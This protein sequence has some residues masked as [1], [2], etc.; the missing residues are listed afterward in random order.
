MAEPHGN[1][2]LLPREILD[3]VVD[4]FGP[5]TL[6]HAYSLPAETRETLLACVRVSHAWRAA[7]LPHLYKRVHL[8]TAKQH[9]SFHNAIVNNLGLAS[10][11][12]HLAV[13]DFKYSLC[14]P[15]LSTFTDIVRRICVERKLRSFYV[16]KC[17]MGFPDDKDLSEQN[18]EFL[19]GTDPSACY[20]MVTELRRS[21]E[22]LVDNTREEYALKQIVSTFLDFF[23]NRSR[24]EGLNGGWMDHHGLHRLAMRS[25]HITEEMIKNVGWRRNMPHLRTLIIDDPVV[26]ALYK[27]GKL[28]DM[29]ESLTHIAMSMHPEA[30]LIL[31][32]N[33]WNIKPWVDEFTQMKASKLKLLKECCRMTVLNK[34]SESVGWMDDKALDGT[35]WTIVQDKHNENVHQLYP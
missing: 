30:H 6:E 18:R 3:Q 16:H 34:A 29:L 10:H 14:E 5:P 12:E 26:P 15:A 4:Y 31:A 33:Y 35:L 8:A 27:A 32:T 11:V 23:P 2:G 7:L 17:L 20:I 28:S 21:M 22:L 13:E 19:G 24:I 1:I 25:L 9:E